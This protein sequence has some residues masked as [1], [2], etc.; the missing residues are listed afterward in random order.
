LRAERGFDLALLPAETRYSWLARA[1]DSDT[2]VAFDERRARPGNWLVTEWRRYPG[3]PTA[4]V[5]VFAAL[6]DGPPPAPYD[7]KDWA[8]PPCAPFARPRSPYCVLHLGARNPN[9]LWNA[10]RWRRL[11]D[12]ASARGFTVVLSAGRGQEELVRGVD[13]DGGLPA[14]AGD[15]DLAQMWYL[16]RDAAFVVCPDTGIAHLAAITATP[17]VVLFGQGSP[18]VTGPGE[19]WRHSRFAAVWEEDIACRDQRVLFG[20]TVPW[21]RRCARAPG[22]CDEPVCMHVL[23]TGRVIAALEDLLGR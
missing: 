8:M 2:I 10:E 15:L 14:F 3:T 6:I 20:R 21:V 23:D 19:F 9:R 7:P 17:V 12:W 18:R 1:L 5:D 4:L 11:A 13:P 16:L 22:E